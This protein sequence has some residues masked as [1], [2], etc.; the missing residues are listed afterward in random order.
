ME[1]KEKDH[2]YKHNQL[3]EIG[4]GREEKAVL[5]QRKIY[6]ISSKKAKE[7]LYLFRGRKMRLAQGDRA[8][9]KE[10]YLPKNEYNQLK[11]IKKREVVPT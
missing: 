9:R 1:K 5:A 3:R 2:I 6:A 7:K 4:N 11:E 10:F 8:R